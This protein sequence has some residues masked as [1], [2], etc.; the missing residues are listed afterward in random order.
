MNYIFYSGYIF[1]TIIS[2]L[3]LSIIFQKKTIFIISI[4][5][6]IFIFYFFRDINYKIHK[7]DSQINSPCQG[8]VLKIIRNNDKIHIAVFLSPLDIHIQYTPC[9]GKIIG[10]KYK[11]GEFNMAHLFEKSNYNERMET[12]IRNPEFGDVLILQIAGLL[13]RRIVPFYNIGDNLEQNIPFGL[14]RFGSRVDIILEDNPDYYV[15]IKEGFK[16][17]IGDPLI[18]KL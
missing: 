15:F 11:K 3:I 6:T 10:Q 7:N 14:I 18:K 13:A 1:P 9:K 8:T 2:I 5:I 16:I 12:T 17:K 4:I